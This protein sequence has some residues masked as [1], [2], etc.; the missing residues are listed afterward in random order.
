MVIAMKVELIM[1]VNVREFKEYAVRYK[2]GIFSKWQFV[3][4]AKGSNALF[5][6]ANASLKRDELLNGSREK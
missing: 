2:K 1:F 5:N 4:N 3:K 6:F